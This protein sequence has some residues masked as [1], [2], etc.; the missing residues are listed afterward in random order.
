M[1]NYLNKIV[2]LT[3]EQ[4]DTLTNIGSININGQT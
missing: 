1:S 3:D 4:Y 2:Y